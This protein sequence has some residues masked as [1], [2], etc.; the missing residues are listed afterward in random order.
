MDDFHPKRHPNPKFPIAHPELP[1]QSLSQFYTLGCRAASGTYTASKDPPTLH[2]NTHWI[3][4]A[5]MPVARQ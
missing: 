3:W 4:G 2:H 1:S 5:G